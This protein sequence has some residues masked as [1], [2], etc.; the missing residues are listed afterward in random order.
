MEASKQSG[1]PSQKKFVHVFEKPYGYIEDQIKSRVQTSQEKSRRLRQENENLRN[2]EKA[3][4]SKW[5][6]TLEK[7]K[8]IDLRC[9]SHLSNYLK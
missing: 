1:S 5:I 2:Q 3:A 9:N 6:E 8:S 4:D 7:A